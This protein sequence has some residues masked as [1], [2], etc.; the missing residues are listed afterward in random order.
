[1]LNKPSNMPSTFELVSRNCNIKENAV[2][3]SLGV[4]C[5]DDSSSDESVEDEIIEHMCTQEE[6][7]VEDMSKLVKDC[8]FNWFEINERL[9]KSYGPDNNQLQK[10][11]LHMKRTC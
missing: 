7:T 2:L 9:Q 10:L 4:D 3:R 11:L 6:L 1:M 8:Q 5:D